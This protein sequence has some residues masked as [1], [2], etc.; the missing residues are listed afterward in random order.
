LKH[1]KVVLS[2]LIQEIPRAILWLSPLV[3]YIE[4]IKKEKR[5]EMKLVRKHKLF[6]GVVGAAAVLVI[7][8]VLVGSMISSATSEK[9]TVKVITSGESLFKGY[10][11][12]VKIDG[13]PLSDDAHWAALPTFSQFAGPEA[14]DRP[15][16]KPAVRDNIDGVYQPG[17]IIFTIRADTPEELQKQLNEVRAV[18]SQ[19][20]TDV[21]KGKEVKEAEENKLPK[22]GTV[23]GEFDAP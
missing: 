19:Y 10:Y 6:F 15:T 2:N 20:L 16:L 11:C 13:L 9:V 3:K 18:V 8:A 1:G 5:R 14:E 12:V 21:K 23:V 7:I 22:S 4:K 17:N